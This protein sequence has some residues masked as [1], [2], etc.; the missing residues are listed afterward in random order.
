MIRYTRHVF[1]LTVCVWILYSCSEKP[2]RSPAARNKNT[3]KHPSTRDPRRFSRWLQADLESRA[4]EIL[5]EEQKSAAVGEWSVEHD[6]ATAA[7]SRKKERGR[8]KSRGN[9]AKG[10]AA[11]KSKSGKSR[12]KTPGG[13]AGK[14]AD[15]GEKD[16][17][18]GSKGKATAGKG[19]GK[20]KKTPTQAEKGPS[21]I[22]SGGTTE[23][24]RGADRQGAAAK[25]QRSPSPAKKGAAKGK[26]QSQK[27]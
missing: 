16:D 15:K 24:K 22:N 20:G 4:F 2:H 12:S 1:A 10:G 3:N 27:K 25:A 26:K 14:A 5:D 23:G 17:D 8:P 19:K 6:E 13:K 11:D 21:P 9:K 18:R 7:T